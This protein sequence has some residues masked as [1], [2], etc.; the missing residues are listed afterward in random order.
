MT[1]P[2]PNACTPISFPLMLLVQQQLT[3]DFNVEILLFL[4]NFTTPKKK[5]S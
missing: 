5:L 4:S 1:L 3:S 2:L